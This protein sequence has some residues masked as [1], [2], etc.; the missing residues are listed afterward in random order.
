MSRAIRA[1]SW[2]RKRSFH[3]LFRCRYPWRKY[4]FDDSSFLEECDA[5]D[6]AYEVGEDGQRFERLFVIVA[7]L[8]PWDPPRFAH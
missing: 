4:Y 2:P 8:R 3:G 5:F 7:R 6:G 1:R